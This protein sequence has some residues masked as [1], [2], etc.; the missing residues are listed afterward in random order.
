MCLSPVRPR[1]PITTISA[2]IA[3]TTSRIL[4][5]GRPTRSMV[6]VSLNE[7]AFRVPGGKIF[8][9]LDHHFLGHIFHAFD[10]PFPG[11]ARIESRCFA[12]IVHD[13]QHDNR[14]THTPRHFHRENKRFF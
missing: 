6:E 8:H 1:L 2:L 9:E 5:T 10:T 12:R 11:L 3:S 14:G 4:V 7:S 13:V